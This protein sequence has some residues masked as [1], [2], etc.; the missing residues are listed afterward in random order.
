MSNKRH[1]CS[2]EVVDIQTSFIESLQEQATMTIIKQ[3]NGRYKVTVKVGENSESSEWTFLSL[4]YD[5]AVNHMTKYGIG[6]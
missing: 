2:M 4:C 1:T 5:W 3:E 6:V